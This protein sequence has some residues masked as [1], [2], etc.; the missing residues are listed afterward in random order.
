MRCRVWPD[1]GDTPIRR[2]RVGFGSLSLVSTP[3]DDRVGRILPLPRD[4]SDSVSA[5]TRE[6]GHRTTILN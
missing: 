3:S 1:F 5:S 2:P 4:R 6:A